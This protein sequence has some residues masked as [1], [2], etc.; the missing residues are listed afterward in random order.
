[1]KTRMKKIKLIILKTE[2][3]H[4]L[5]RI[6]TSLF[7]SFK[8]SSNWFLCI[9]ILHF[10]KTWREWSRDIFYE[11][12]YFCIT[13]WP[14]LMGVFCKMQVHVINYSFITWNYISIYSILWKLLMRKRIG[15]C[16]NRRSY[17]RIPL[18]FSFEWK[19]IF[20]EPSKLMCSCKRAVSP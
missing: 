7:I 5:K 4:I 16:E 20:H 10:V 8:R 12:S 14:N 6:K 17:L 15:N 19:I 2:V 13:T 3:L 1:M 11:N 9:V 18:L